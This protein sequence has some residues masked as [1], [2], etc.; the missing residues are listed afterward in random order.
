MSLLPAP[1]DL[2]RLPE[3]ASSGRFEEASFED[4]ALF[5]PG[6]TTPTQDDPSY[7]WREAALEPRSGTVKKTGGA[8]TVPGFLL[9]RRI[10]RE[11]QDKHGRKARSPS[12]AVPYCCPGCGTDYSPRYRAANTQRREG[13]LSPVRSFRTGFGKTSQL[14]ASELTAFL[15]AQGGDGKLVAF[16]DSRQDAANLALN[17]EEQHQRDLRRELLAG[18]VDDFAAAE[19]PDPEELAALVERRKKAVVDED[20]ETISLLQPRIK[21]LERRFAGADQQPSVPLSALLEF[22]KG[23]PADGT[24]RPVLDR[25]VALGATIPRASRWFVGSASRTMR[26]ASR[27]RHVGNGKRIVCRPP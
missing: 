18:S 19:R 22:E 2:E 1:Q 10:S 11:A 6:T 5:W 26:S 20:Y 13:R 15:K 27:S 17:I 25:L 4:Y 8:G 9:D 23:R 7:V 24:L 16:S 21:D 12:T 3:S 14:L